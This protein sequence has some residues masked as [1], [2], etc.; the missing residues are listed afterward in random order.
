MNRLERY[1]SISVLRA[2]LIALLVFMS[3]LIF[4]GFVDEMD[5][6]GKG[7]FT[8]LDAF[9]VALLSAP[10]YSFEVFPVAAL[11]GGLLGLGGLARHGELVAMRAMGMSP[12]QIALA[13]VK[14][15]V[16]LM[17]AVFL[18]G[19][20][21][22]PVSEAYAQRMKVEKQ[23]EK[24]TFR[25]EYGFWARDGDAFVNIRDILPDGRLEEISIYEF[26]RNKRLTLATTAAS[27]QH[28]DGRWVLSDI[29]Q[30]RLL[31]DRVENR[32]LAEASWSSLLDPALLSLV[33]VKPN[34][35]PV[36]GLRDYIN[37]MR[38]NGQNPGLYEMA[39]WSKVSTPLASMALLLFALPFVLGSPRA[40]AGAGQQM[41]FGAMAGAVF[42]L[43]SR[44]FSFGAV[45]YDFSPLLAS[46]LPPLLFLAGAWWLGRRYS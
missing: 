4:L 7:R 35:L 33:V 32:R 5:E 19:E 9:L 36:W 6:V 23:Q 25:S 42:F 46:M 3:L 18:I 16:L 37:F 24:I 10:R 11:F 27:A 15:G 29:H 39:F 1:L 34:M 41:L 13:L 30:R 8:T 38:A 28:R 26:D 45:A 40:G 20:V 43:V 12:L 21:L 17:L 14:A 22:A 31:A 44:G 2:V